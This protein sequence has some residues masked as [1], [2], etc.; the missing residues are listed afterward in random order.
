MENKLY[1]NETG[2]ILR[3]LTTSNESLVI[4]ED[5]KKEIFSKICNSIKFQNYIVAKL[6]IYAKITEEVLL[7][8]LLYNAINKEIT[9]NLF[10]ENPSKYC[11]TYMFNILPEN[12][13]SLKKILNGSEINDLVNI[14]NIKNMLS[15]IGNCNS[16][17]LKEL[18]PKAF[19]F[20]LMNPYSQEIY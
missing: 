12:L 5:L 19:H 18:F 9:F 8:F 11:N 20:S 4:S 3:K 14:L 10:I 13:P 16:D 7:N 2:K 17:K 1:W 15:E 6:L